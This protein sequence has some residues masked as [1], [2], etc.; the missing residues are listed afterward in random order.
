MSGPPIVFLLGVLPE[1]LQNSAIPWPR[2]AQEV[3]CKSLPASQLRILLS[4]G[5][6]PAFDGP[7]GVVF[8]PRRK[9]VFQ[10][11]VGSLCRIVRI[12]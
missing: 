11:Q 12:V 8:T 2:K 4:F 9:T 6:V 7:S 1:A 5:P 3:I 10:Q